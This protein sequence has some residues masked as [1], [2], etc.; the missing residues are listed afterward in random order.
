LPSILRCAKIYPASVAPGVMLWTRMP[1]AFASV[2][3]W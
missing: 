1:D 3:Q 2:A